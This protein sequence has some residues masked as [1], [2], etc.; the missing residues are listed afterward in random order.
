[1]RLTHMI[2]AIAAGMLISF[3]GGMELANVR[4]DAAEQLASQSQQTMLATTNAR[5]AAIVSAAAAWQSRAAACEDKFKIVTLLVEPRPAAPGASMPIL[6]GA[7]A[8]SLSNTGNSG[9]LRVAWAIPAQVEPQSTLPGA[10]YVWIDHSDPG[11]DPGAD[12]KILGTYFAKIVSP[13]Q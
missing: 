5:A 8:L 10:Q 11:A 9:G 3:A 2:A 12:G 7:L 1:M 4:H 13:A 6:G